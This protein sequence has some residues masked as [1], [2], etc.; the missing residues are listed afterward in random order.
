MDVRIENKDVKIQSTG[1]MDYVESL[2]ELLVIKDDLEA[3]LNSIS[4]SDENI[5]ILRKERG[6]V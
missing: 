2:E 4:H 1:E 6:L 5:E 3:R